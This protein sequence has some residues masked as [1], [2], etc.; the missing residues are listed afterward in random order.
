MMLLRLGQLETKL[1]K[2]V[3]RFCGVYYILNILIHSY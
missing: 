3:H 2:P 1:L